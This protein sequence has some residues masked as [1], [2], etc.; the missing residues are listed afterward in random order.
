[1]STLQVGKQKPCYG[2]GDERRDV[3][4]VDERS[5]HDLDERCTST[6]HAQHKGAQHGHAQQGHARATRAWGAPRAG[7]GW[8]QAGSHK[9]WANGVMSTNCDMLTHVDDKLHEHTVHTVRARKRAQ[10]GH[11]E[12]RP[13]VRAQRGHARGAQGTHART[14][15]MFAMSCSACVDFRGRGNAWHCA[16]MH[17]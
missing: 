8:G 5:P 4:D 13:E 17:S 14:W 1:M 6:T 16:A 11:T 7:T 3:G 15:C 10:R 12:R 2:G 9:M